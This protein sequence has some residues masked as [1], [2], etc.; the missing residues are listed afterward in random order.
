MQL[1][2][3]TVMQSYRMTSRW[4]NNCSFKQ[5]EHLQKHANGSNFRCENSEII[6]A[7]LFGAANLFPL[8]LFMPFYDRIIY[9]WLSGWKW[10]SMLARMAWGNFFIVVS[11]LSAIAIEVVRVEVLSS[12]L[13]D[14]GTVTI[15]AFSFREGVTSYEVASPL[16][17]V[18][19]AIP[20][21]FFAFAE[22]FSNITGK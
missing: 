11:I 5:H 16:H 3:T 6:P 8:L 4:V 22:V 21:F 13:R 7:L 18:Y 19:L 20:F 2:S 17:N 10:F 9:T 14:N 1:Q 12:K 15:N